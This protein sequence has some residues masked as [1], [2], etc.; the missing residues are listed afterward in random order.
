VGVLTN[1]VLATV[2]VLV[3]AKTTVVKEAH[4]S[5]AVAPIVVTLLGIVIVEMAVLVNTL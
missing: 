1:A 3:K 2:A 5:N 4:A